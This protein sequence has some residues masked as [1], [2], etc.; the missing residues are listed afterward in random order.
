MSNLSSMTCNNS[1]KYLVHRNTTKY[2]KSG[3]WSMDN[4]WFEIGIGIVVCCDIETQEILHLMPI[5]VVNEEG[6]DPA[7]EFTYLQMIAVQ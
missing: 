6:L 3:W 7:S 2:F 5:D 1:K 4:Y